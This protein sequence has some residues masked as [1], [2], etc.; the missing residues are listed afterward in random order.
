MVPGPLVP[1]ELLEK[2][3]IGDRA[4]AHLQLHTPVHPCPAG[5]STGHLSQAASTHAL[6]GRHDDATSPGMAL[7]GVGNAEVHLS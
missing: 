3:D 5:G 2:E 1:G 7:T 4:K 6:S